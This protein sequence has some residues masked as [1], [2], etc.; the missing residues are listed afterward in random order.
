MTSKMWLLTLCSSI[1][2]E[3]KDN[4][5]DENEVIE[6][7]HEDDETGMEISGNRDELLN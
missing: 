5:R 4:S 7:Q 6:V 1:S 2:S 3:A